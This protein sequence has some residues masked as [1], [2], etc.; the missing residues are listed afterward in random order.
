MA[1]KIL[2]AVLLIAAASGVLANPRYIV[3]LNAQA[4]NEVLSMRA[5]TSVD[6]AAV[7]NMQCID[8]SV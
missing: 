6:P 3:P 1:S 4:H 8:T 5:S 2:R 7:S